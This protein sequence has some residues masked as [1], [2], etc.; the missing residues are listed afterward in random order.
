MTSLIEKIASDAV[1][2]EAFA[3]L[4]KRRENYHH[5][6]DVWH[7]RFHWPVLKPLIQARLL[8]GE[9]CFE[10][11]TKIWLWNL[12]RP[13][14]LWSSV[15][16]L[17][18][19]AVSLVLTESLGPM[20]GKSCYHLPGMG[21]CKGAV[22]AVQQGVSDARFV[23]KSDVKQYYAGIDHH[24]LMKQLGRLIDDDKTLDLIRGHLEH[25]VDDGGELRLRTRG[26]L[27]GSPLSP[28]L[29]AIYLKPLDDAMA[30]QDVFYVRFMDDWIVLTK[31]RWKLRGA[32]KACNEVLETLKIEKHPFKTFIGRVAHGF[33]FVGYRFTTE[34]ARGVEVAWQTL[35][36][37]L[38]KV[39]RLYEQ[40]A[41]TDRIGQYIKGWWQWVR[42]GVD[43]LGAYGLDIKL[44]WQHL[45]KQRGGHGCMTNVPAPNA[46]PLR[47]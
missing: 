17:V 4:C 47:S 11:V 6:S 33:D 38:E 40:G 20:L 23:F 21:G 30:A 37:H 28:L 39:V 2:D 42:A 43:L 44:Y 16:A 36:N 13:L 45:V 29:G 19:K 22:R 27:R 9:H 14:Y 34:S 1:I 10:P 26:V 35:S 3:W 15:D 46:A 5:N 18:L 8:A 25:L 32:V 41:D 12:V 7:L 31:S 24:V